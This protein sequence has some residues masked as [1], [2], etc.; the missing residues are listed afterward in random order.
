M[1]NK[2]RLAFWIFFQVKTLIPHNMFATTVSMLNF[3]YNYM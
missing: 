1:L 3:R 2:T